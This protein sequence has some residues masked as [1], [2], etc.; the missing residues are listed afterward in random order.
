[1][2]ISRAVWQ[3]E[4][5]MDDPEVNVMIIIKLFRC[6]KKKKIHSFILFI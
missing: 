2:E 4:V 3:E 5:K 6:S 1:M